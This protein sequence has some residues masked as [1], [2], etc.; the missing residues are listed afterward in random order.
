MTR[1]LK[2]AATLALGWGLVGVG[3]VGL[4]LPVLQGVLMIA[5]GL[6]VLSRESQTVYRWVERARRRH[7]VLDR[8]LCEVR[9][10]FHRRGQDDRDLGSAPA[11]VD[12]GSDG[13]GRKDH[14]AAEER[15]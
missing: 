7:P 13:G 12:P 4:F 6:Y 10:R 14:G 5:L 2:R 1:H 3:I 11:A 9:R 8:G 15:P